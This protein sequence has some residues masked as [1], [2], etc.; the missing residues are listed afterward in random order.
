MS[1]S[2]CCASSSRSSAASIARLWLQD[3]RSCRPGWV[4][5]RVLDSSAMVDVPREP[6]TLCVAPGLVARAW[7]YRLAGTGRPPLDRGAAAADPPPGE[8]EPALGLPPHPGRAPAARPQLSALAIPRCCAAHGFHPA[9][10]RRRGL[11]RLPR[12]AAGIACDFFTVETASCTPLRPVLPRGGH[13]PCPPRRLTAN[14][15]APWVTQQARDL[16]V[17]SLSGA[18]P[19]SAF[20]LRDRDAKFSSAGSTPSSAVEAVRGDLARRRGHLTGERVLL[21]A[22]WGRCAA[23]ASTGC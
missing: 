17:G 1:R 11:A 5:A 16:R 7:T 20:L 2:W 19:A 10:P 4:W 3:R 18:R 23:T 9:P 12:A 22:G 21:S 15:T 13:A 14:P 6:E 8:G